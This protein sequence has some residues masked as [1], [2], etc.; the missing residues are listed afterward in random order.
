MCIRDR[1]RTADSGY[2][3]RRL[4]DVA[5]ELIVK[6]FDCATSRGMWIEHVAPDTRA[7]RAHLETKLWG[8]VVS[9]SVTLSDGSTIE[10]GTMSVSYTHLPGTYL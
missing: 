10:A 7:Q 2:L 6:E 9:E 3:T 4:V 8:R 5:Q 1:L